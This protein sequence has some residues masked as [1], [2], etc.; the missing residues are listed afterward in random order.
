M[1]FNFVSLARYQPEYY[2]HGL[3]LD[4]LVHQ[5]R[6]G[7]TVASWLALLCQ[8]KEVVGSVPAVASFHVYHLPF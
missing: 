6:G 3:I 2:K 4:H 1:A 5:G 7:G 8:D